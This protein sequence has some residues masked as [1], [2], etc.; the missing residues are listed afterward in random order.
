MGLSIAG[1][2]MGANASKKSGKAQ[3]E[4]AEYNAELQEIKADDA[5]VRG[6]EAEHRLRVSARGMIGASRAAFAASGVEVNDIDSTATNVQ[7]DI[8]SLSEVDALTIRSNAAREA[9]GY[10]TA[11]TELRKRGE[12][13]EEE[14]KQKAI[15]TLTS[16][17]GSLLYQ[18]Y[19][20][21]STGRLKT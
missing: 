19:G 1:S 15:G 16:T 2:L 4:V 8:K 20:F 9:W 11:A 12:I 21:G 6:G 13:A 7:A 5:I 14:G 3:R 18:K 17:A 10:R